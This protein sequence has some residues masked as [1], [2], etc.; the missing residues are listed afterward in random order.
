MKL[1][2]LNDIFENFTLNLLAE[3]LLNCLVWPGLVSHWSGVRSE[4][5]TLFAQVNG[6]LLLAVHYGNEVDC[7]L[8]L[9]TF[10]ANHKGLSALTTARARARL[11][12]ITSQPF[13]TPHHLLENVLPQS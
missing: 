4:R 6:L 10:S 12:P 3:F 2:V 1:S 11:L 8:V 7:C 13:G 9:V 5:G